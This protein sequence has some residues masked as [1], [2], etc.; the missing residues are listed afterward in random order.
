ME[1][2]QQ[3]FTQYP[4][5]LPADVKE[6]LVRRAAQ[7]RRSL[8]NEMVVRL[9]NSLKAEEMVERGAAQ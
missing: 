5:R 6:Q 4:L 8:N 2:E 3:R 9:E 1:S 7:A